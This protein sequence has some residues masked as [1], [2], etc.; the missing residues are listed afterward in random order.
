MINKINSGGFGFGLPNSNSVSVTSDNGQPAYP[1]PATDVA[2]SMRDKV[3]GTKYIDN[4]ELLD[5]NFAVMPKHNSQAELPI[6]TPIGTR[7][8]WQSLEDAKL[9]DKW[10][11]SY[12]IPGLRRVGIPS[13]Q[14]RQE[15]IKSQFGSSVSSLVSV[16][17]DAYGHRTAIPIH[18]RDTG[19]RTHH[20][21]STCYFR[22]SHKNIDYLFKKIIEK[23]TGEGLLSITNQENTDVRLVGSSSFLDRVNA[24]FAGI[25]SNYLA[26]PA[27][28]V[29]LSDGLYAV[30]YNFD[31]KHNDP[32]VRKSIDQ[33]LT[34]VHH[35]LGAT[36]SYL[37]ISQYL[38]TNANPG[39]RI[40]YAKGSNTKSLDKFNKLKPKL[41]QLEEK[42]KEFPSDTRLIAQLSISLVEH[43]EG[44]IY[45]GMCNKM[46][47]DGL[48]QIGNLIAGLSV[49]FDD[50]VGSV[51]IYDLLVDEISLMLSYMKPYNSIDINAEQNR[52]YSN[53]LPSVKNMK[54]VHIKSLATSSSGMGA[55]STGLFEAR[56]QFGFSGIDD[57]KLNINYFEVTGML[58]LSGLYAQGHP[59]IMTTLNPSIPLTAANA[60]EIIAKTKETLER[61]KESKVP[62]YLVIDTTVD[63]GDS[64]LDKIVSQLQEPLESGAINIV[65]CRSFQKYASLGTGKIM[66]GNITTINNG[67]DRYRHFESAIYSVNQEENFFKHNNGQLLV[68]LLKC[69]KQSLSVIQQAAD[70]AKF[71]NDFCWPETGMDEGS[72]YTGGLP[73]VVR[74]DTSKLTAASVM[75][76]C[77][78][79]QRDTFGFIESSVCP[80][81]SQNKE[82]DFL[83]RI[84]A[85]VDTQEQL[86]ERFFCMGHMWGQTS[87]DHMDDMLN[88]LDNV[89]GDT[90]KRV[91]ESLIEKSPEGII[92]ADDS[93]LESVSNDLSVSSSQV[94]EIINDFA[95]LKGASK[96]SDRLQLDMLIRY[97]ANITASVI[98]AMH[99][100]GKDDAF[101]KHADHFIANGFR[102]HVQNA[103]A[104]HVGAVTYSSKEFIF[105]H[106]FNQLIESPES[107]DLTELDKVI[108]GVPARTKLGALLKKIPDSFFDES[109]PSVSHDLRVGMMNRL[110]E[111]VPFKEL[112]G[113]GKLSLMMDENIH[114]AKAIVRALELRGTL[115]TEAPDFFLDDIN[116]ALND[117]IDRQVELNFLQG[118]ISTHTHF[119]QQHKIMGFL[120]DSPCHI[121]LPLL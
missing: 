105:S 1:V 96:L 21:D 35:V 2:K 79:Q 36:P 60:D 115:Q 64:K 121:L 61:Y 63:T 84:N 77:G 92:G 39:R 20:K 7:V 74:Y 120:N 4:L 12:N 16:L 48:R 76:Y 32:S 103:E 54:G 53:E 40:T 75:E 91:I 86:V 6:G 117:P 106:R 17:I 71:I 29:R 80:I 69:H 59:I 97:A 33:T 107:I 108:S 55:I 67:D 18:A 11:I 49:S 99:A 70:G 82:G 66:A 118:M 112:V 15:S 58:N 26:E 56:Q 52:I 30:V 62:V 38:S 113:I 65:L 23:A 72:G 93:V 3:G 109:N 41:A 119:S 28:I 43:F 78:T 89:C 57:L 114:K 24:L 116:G 83:L 101:T 111:G 42:S 25:E 110:A 22:D 50:F 94:R 88:G 19:I 27:K 34:R 73:F 37:S 5:D 68:H 100:W 87:T 44:K 81:N 8:Q 45:S 13:S 14:V 46:V 98:K 51:Q 31:P 85:G 102:A 90:G 10:A 47:N 9:R 95:C 104:E